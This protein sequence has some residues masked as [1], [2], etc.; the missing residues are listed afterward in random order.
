MKRIAMG[1]RPVALVMVAWLVVVG[2]AHVQAGGH[3]FFGS[4]TT[5]APARSLDI[6]TQVAVEQSLD[7]DRLYSNWLDRARGGYYNSGPRR[8]VARFFSNGGFFRRGR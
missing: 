3:D 1:G 5:A 4:T 2:P 7:G 8:P 6:D